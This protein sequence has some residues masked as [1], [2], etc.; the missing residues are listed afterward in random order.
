MFREWLCPTL[1]RPWNSPVNQA[2][3]ARS[4]CGGRHPGQLLTLALDGSGWFSTSLRWI[5]YTG[6]PFSLDSNT[7]EQSFLMSK[8]PYFWR[9]WC[10]ATDISEIQ[11]MCF[12]CC[13][14]W[15]RNRPALRSYYGLRQRGSVPL[16]FSEHHQ[17]WNW[18]ANSAPRERGAFRTGGA[19]SASPTIHVS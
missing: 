16:G 2:E 12:L 8:Y 14:F 11:D 10:Q 18:R 5:T 13:L 7:K 17:G 9:K 1:V 4:I 19:S 6:L 15:M 3:S